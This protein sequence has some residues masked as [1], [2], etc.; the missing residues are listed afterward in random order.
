MSWHWHLLLCNACKACSA[1]ACSMGHGRPLCS[2]SAWLS[3]HVQVHRC[4]LSSL[5]NSKESIRKKALTAFIC[6]QE[7]AEGE[8]GGPA[9]ECE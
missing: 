9:K 1:V 2:T 3:E 5:R 7:E 8:P 6:L 4:S